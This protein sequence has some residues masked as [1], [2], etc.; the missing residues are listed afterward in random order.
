MELG[1]RHLTLVT[2]LMMAVLLLSGCSQSEEVV[3]ESAITVNTAPAQIRDL[4]KSVLYTGTVRGQNEVYLMPKVLARV[5]GIHAQPGD[6]VRAGQ[7]LITLDNTD[8]IAGVK[9]AEALLALA[10]AGLQSNQIQAENARLNYERIQALH[11]AGAVSDQQLEAS[12]A[13]YEALIAGSAE[14]SV[15]QAEA[16]LMAARNTLNNCIITSPINGVVGTISLSLGDTANPSAV[17]AIVSN[18]SQLEVEVMVSETEVSYIQK[19]SPVDVVVRAVRDEPFLGEVKSISTV[20]DPVKRNYPVKVSLPNTEGQIKSG[21]F[22]ELTI[23]TMSKQGI[24]TVP[25][26]AVIPKGGQ[27][28]VYLVDGESRA[29]VAEVTTGIKN[30]QYIEI[31]SGLTAGQEVIVK[32]NTLVSDGTLVRVVGGGQ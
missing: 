25:V 11:E 16:G 30:D 14:A 9:Q 28:I 6:T 24:L 10:Q 7:T 27:D 21:M 20:A 23:D 32:G 5:T 22:A 31:V 2:V 3:K 18:T 15:A 19:G 12:R 17:A 29:Q 13:A 4:A 1:K 26:G 8:F